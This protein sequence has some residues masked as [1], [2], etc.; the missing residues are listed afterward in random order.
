M[1]LCTICHG[2]TPPAQYTR[3]STIC[4]GMSP[5]LYML[6][7]VPS[8]MVQPLL[9]CIVPC[10]MVCSIHSLIT[11]CNSKPMLPSVMVQACLYACYV[12]SVLASL[13]LYAHYITIMDG[14]LKY[15][16]SWYGRLLHMRMI[17]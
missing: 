7:M 6:D 9:L 1:L 13:L 16:L 3:Y 10:V 14:T 11:I 2:M 15:H 4:Y 17:I 5:P 12:P 8:V